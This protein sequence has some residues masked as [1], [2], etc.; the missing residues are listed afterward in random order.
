MALLA[1]LVGYSRVY[2]GVHYPLDVIGGWI[3][4]AGCGWAVFVVFKKFIFPRFGITLQ[5][6]TAAS[7]KKSGDKGRR[8]A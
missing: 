3:L 7:H 1:L 2:L 5:S 6:L 8:P 4:G